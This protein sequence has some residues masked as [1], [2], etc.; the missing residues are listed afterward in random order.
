MSPDAA[1]RSLRRRAYWAFLRSRVSAGWLELLLALAI[2]GAAALVVREP[3][4][5]LAPALVLVA[6]TFAWTLGGTTWARG[7]LPGLLLGV[8]PLGCSLSAA[9]LGHVC[10][11]GGCASLCVPLCAA[12][13]V[14]AGLLLARAARATR[15]PLGLWLAGGSIVLATGS[16][17]CACVGLGGLGGMLAGFLPSAALLALP[18]RA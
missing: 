2:V 18:R 4:P 5:V 17:G 7:V 3:G 6:L 10:W 8:V 11:N 14:V 9:R 12:G 1:N 16:L 13:G 15:H